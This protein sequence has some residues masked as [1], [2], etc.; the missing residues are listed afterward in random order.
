MSGF[1]SFATAASAFATSSAAR[2]SGAFTSVASSQPIAS[3][4][5]SASRARAAP[6]VTTETT[7]L[8]SW[9]FRSSASSIAY[10][11]YGEIDQVTPSVAIDRP[12]APTFTRTVESGTCL[13]QTRNLIS[14]PLR[15]SLG[16]AGR[17]QL[18]DVDRLD[19]LGDAL[20][21]DALLQHDQT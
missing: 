14:A 4:C 8:A 11:S 15:R 18:E 13:R 9:S 17:D 16:Q 12:S 6:T 1:I 10:S 5:R 2:S 19:L 3:A 20:R 21:A 7:V